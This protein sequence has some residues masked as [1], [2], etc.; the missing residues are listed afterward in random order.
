MASTMR[1]SGTLEDQGHWKMT[2]RTP[3]SEDRAVGGVG[4]QGSGGDMWTVVCLRV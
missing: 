3:V 4:S 2:G 1:S